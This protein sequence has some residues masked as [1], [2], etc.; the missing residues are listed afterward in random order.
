MALGHSVKGQEF[1]QVGLLYADAMQFYAAELRPG[2]AKLLR[3]LLTCEARALAESA[4]LCRE[5]ATANGSALLRHAP[6]LLS[7]SGDS[8]RV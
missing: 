5:A 1:A 6:G 7:I 8:G 4:Q 2:P 3:H